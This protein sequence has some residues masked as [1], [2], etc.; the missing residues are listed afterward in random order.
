VTQHDG[1]FTQDSNTRTIM[2]VLKQAR[3]ENSHSYLQAAEAIEEASKRDH[4]A[5]RIKWRHRITG[6]EY[7]AMEQGITK[8]VPLWVVMYLAHEYRI[9]ADTLVGGLLEEYLYG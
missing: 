9:N 3:E 4:D 5:G 7:R 8:N 1:P 2:L 6:D